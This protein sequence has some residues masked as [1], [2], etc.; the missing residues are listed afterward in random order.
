MPP[1][2]AASAENLTSRLFLGPALRTQS[3]RRLVTLVREGYEAAFEEIVRRYRT[4]LDRFAAAIVGGRSEDVTQDAFSKALLALRGSEAEIELRP[5]LY[6]IVRNTALNELRDSPPEAADLGEALAGG[7]SAAEE[8]ER[9]Q[10]MT[11]LMERLRALPEPQ[12]AAIVM[13]ELEGLSHEE[14]AAALGVSGGA[15]RQA[16]FRARQALRDGLGL[17]LPLPL[18]RALIDHGAEAAGASGAVAGAGAGAAAGAAGAAGGTGAA[19][20]GVGVGGAL[21]VGVATAL[22]A[23][24]VGAGVAVEQRSDQGNKRPAAAETARGDSGAPSGSQIVAS[25]SGPSATAGPGVGRSDDGRGSNDDGGDRQESG[26]SEGRGRGS[27]GDG[28]VIG[29]PGDRDLDHGGPGPRHGGTRHGSGGGGH[30]DGSGHGGHGPRP[31]DDSFGGD[32]S[33]HGGPGPGPRPPS[34]SGGSDSGRG[35]SGHS[36]GGGSGGGSGSG[37]SGGS[38]RDGSGLGSGD[39]GGSGPSA[40][41]LPEALPPPPEGESGDSRDGGEDDS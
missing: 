10:E 13:R 9:R 20:G 40:E 39:G 25:G 41:P 6:R 17:L 8:A 23:G 22:I 37:T 27:G 35:G 2:S 32:G 18:V 33:G 31:S 16:I 19:L 29:I 15:A 5:W 24:S 7:R 3:D 14:I 26:G 11:D 34:S 4:Q 30:D 28:E 21:K 36:G 38:G 1:P 12:R